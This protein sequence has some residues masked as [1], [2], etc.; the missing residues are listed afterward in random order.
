M[1]DFVHQQYRLC[2]GEC[3]QGS[4]TPDAGIF[5]IDLTLQLKLFCM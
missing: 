3:M 5:M 2:A 1:Q 4:G